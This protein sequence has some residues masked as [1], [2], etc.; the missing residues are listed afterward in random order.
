MT[1]HEETSTRIVQYVRPR[2]KGRSAENLRVLL[3]EHEYGAVQEVYRARAIAGS[4]T[5]CGLA[6]RRS[7]MPAGIKVV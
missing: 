1:T 6:V 2:I 7:G 3:G 4:I 5:I